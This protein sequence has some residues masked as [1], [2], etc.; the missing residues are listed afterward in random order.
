MAEMVGR[1]VPASPEETE[2]VGAVGMTALGGFNRG[3]G[4]ERRPREEIEG[5]RISSSDREPEGTLENV[6]P[7]DAALSRGNASKYLS[8]DNSPRAVADVYE[9]GDFDISL[10]EF[11]QRVRRE[12]RQS[13]LPGDLFV[14]A[15]RV[16]K[17]RGAF[18]AF[19]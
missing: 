19:K 15:Q 17:E 3:M 16:S 1:D 2:G 12:K 8:D 7:P 18:P 4:G 5:S 11:G 6:R 10:Q 9:Q 14:A 13:D